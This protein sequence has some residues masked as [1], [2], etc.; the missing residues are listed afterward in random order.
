MQKYGTS[1]YYA[2]LFFPNSLKKKVMELYKFVRVP[3][4][5][6]DNANISDT[7]AYAQ[8][9]AMREERQTAYHQNNTHHTVRWDA[10]SLFHENHIPIEL[11]QAFWH[12][13]LQDT[14][15]KTYATY[16]ELQ[17]YMYG[18]AMVVWEMMCHI[19]GIH[20]DD[21]TTFHYAKKLGE[22]MQLTNFLRDVKEDWLEYGRLYMPEEWL[23]KFSLSYRHIKE[24]STTWIINDNREK[25][26]AYC[27]HHCDALYDEAY[28]G[29]Q[30]LPKDTR[31]AVYL[32]L[33][34]YQQILR[35]IEYNHYNVFAQSARTQRHDK[36]LVLTKEIRKKWDTYKK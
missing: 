33:K 13:M 18:S 27:I 14:S 29:I 2:T 32:S 9:S 11:S 10:V 19:F 12:A 25:Y 26:M 34:L 4:L 21:H 6:V 36:A 3:D 8:L 16:A 7:D 17:E 24:F 30:F 5:V 35:K 22:A 31:K 15:K 23:H 20:G 28:H 1:Y